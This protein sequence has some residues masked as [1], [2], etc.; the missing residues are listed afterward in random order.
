MQAI[1]AW[2]A[3]VFMEFVWSKIAAAWSR[4]VKIEREKSVEHDKNKEVRESLEKAE[5][6]EEIDDAAEKVIDRWKH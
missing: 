2:L 1:L 6:P 3:K 5:T 4:Y